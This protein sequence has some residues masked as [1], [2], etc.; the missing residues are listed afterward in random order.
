MMR[1]SALFFLLCSISVHAWAMAGRPPE[2][3]APQALTAAAMEP[4]PLT[5]KD[6]FD[7]AVLRSETVAIQKEEIEAAEAQF[8]LAASEALGEVHFEM[9]DRRQD[10]QKGGSSGD[11]GSS[12]SD[13]ARRERRLVITQPLFQG[14]KAV[15]ALT[16]AGSLRREQKK[17]WQRAKEL[18]FLDVASAFYGLL[19]EEN[20]FETLE[21]IRR[22]FEDRIREL[23]EREAIGRSRPSEVVSA[24]SRMKGLEAELA[25]VRGSRAVSTHL[26]E[27]LIGV[28]LEGR[29]LVE[30]ELPDLALQEPGLYAEDIEDRADVEA[31]GESVKTAWRGVIVAQSE[32]WPEISVQHI[33]YDRREGFQS[34]LDWDFLF[35]ID[36]PLFQGGE[37]VGKIKEAVSVWK[38]EKLTY[39][40]T[41]RE[42]QR[43]VKEN[44]ALWL[45]SME[46]RRAF[47][48]ALADAEE[49]FRLQKEEY[50]RNLV[51]NLDVLEALQ[52]LLETRRD[53]NHAHYEMK[54]N[55]WRLLVAAGEPV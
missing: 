45:A 6:C 13:P 35:K 55:F 40:L 15:A 2:P 44:Y 1:S 51:S 50:E 32:L 49:N 36:I 33:Q 11:V 28:P 48:A 8:F 31:A 4:E 16:G 42:A 46:R 14:F 26:L 52:S 17:E 7:L 47:D 54:E 27:F 43:E 23:G 38:K 41:H 29:G 30:E 21:E 18:L 37:A 34:S 24:R 12:L 10:I 5:L 3:E 53:A 20:D 22:L 25:R 9:T 39:S 19:R